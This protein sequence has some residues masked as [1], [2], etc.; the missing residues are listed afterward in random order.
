MIMTSVL[1]TACLSG[2][3]EVVLSRLCALYPDHSVLCHYSGLHKQTTRYLAGGTTIII[4]SVHLE[5]T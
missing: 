1:A 3:T 2:R 4:P 5:G